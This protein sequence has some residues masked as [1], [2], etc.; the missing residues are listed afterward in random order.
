MR[1]ITENIIMG[2]ISQE[3][4]WRILT[5]NNSAEMILFNIFFIMIIL[6]TIIFFKNNNGYNSIKWWL[7]N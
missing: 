7:I 2:L 1:F 5:I 3:T 4:F 6:F